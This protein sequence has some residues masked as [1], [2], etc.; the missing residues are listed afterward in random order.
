M[1]FDAVTLSHVEDALS[2]GFK[3]HSTLDDFVIRSGVARPV[4]A[5]ARS[6]AEQ[7]T[8]AAGKFTKAPKRYVVKELLAA[9]ASDDPN[10]DRILAQ[11]VTGL[12]Q[13]PLPDAAPSAVAAVAALK[14][15]ALS[16]RQTRDQQRQSEQEKQQA[17]QRT[18]EHVRERART[19]KQASRDGLHDRFSGLMV[20]SN[21]QARGYLLETFLADLFEHEG[22]QPKGSFKLT[23]E[24]IDGS[25]VWRNRTCLIEAKWVKEPVAGA[26]FGAFNYK[27]EGKTA[28]T[29]GLYISINGYSQE[30]MKGMNAKGALKFVCLDG[31]HIMR[32]VLSEDGLPAILERVWRHADETGEAYLHVGRF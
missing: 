13:I 8:S 10:G 3:Y 30:A 18:A 12:M 31:A 19:A 23:G 15:K 14:E 21:A 7:K 4:L 20:E 17:V 26:D 2:D 24:Q 29:R 25:F 11:I 1:P 22:L 16:D 9:L 28:D 27:I 6:R 5:T 32:S